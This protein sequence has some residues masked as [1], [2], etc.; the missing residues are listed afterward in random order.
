MIAV[1]T[2]FQNAA[3]SDVNAVAYKVLMYLGNYA[4]EEGAGASA[5]SSGAAA[6]Y[7]AS[8][9]IDGDRTEL[10]VGAASAADNDI[11]QSSW[12]STGVPD[13]S[14]VVTLDITFAQERKINRVKLYQLAGHGL[15]SY[16]LSYWDGAAWVV[17]AATADVVAGDQT[18]ITPTNELDVVDF[19]E[20]S[21]TKVRLQ[22]LGTEVPDDFANVVELEVYRAIDISS[23]IR[24]VSVS[25]GRDYKLQDP[26]AAQLSIAGINTDK[27]FS[28][29]YSPTAAEIEEGFVNDELRPGLGIIVKAGFDIFVGDEPE[30]VTI[31]TGSVDSIKPAAGSRRA[32]IACTDATKT[33]LR[34]KDSCKL[35]TSIDVGD[36]IRYVLNRANISDYEMEIDS[37]SIELDYF[38]T[39][40]ED[41]LSTIRDLVQSAADALFHFNT[42]GLAIFSLFSNVVGHDEVFTSQVDWETGTLSG[43]DTT[44]TPGKI[45]IDLN[46]DND[47][48]TSTAGWSNH[49]DPKGSMTMATGDG[50]LVFTADPGSADIKDGFYRLSPE[51]VGEWSF[52]FKYRKVSTTAAGGTGLA[53]AFHVVLFA[54]TVQTDPSFGK[55]T[56]NPFSNGYELWFN[57]NSSAGGGSSTFFLG[58]MDPPFGYVGPIISGGSQNFMS[59]FR[60]IKVRRT[61]TGLWSLFL[62]GVLLGTATDT[63]HSLIPGTSFTGQ[64][65]WT[66]DTTASNT[67]WEYKIR[68]FETPSSNAGVGIWTSPTIDMT[69]DL[70]A[71]GTL[72]FTHV[73]NSGTVTYETRSSPDGSAWDAWVAIDGGTG[74]ILSAL[75]RY[76]QVRIT[77]SFL[78]SLSP[79]VS[80]ITVNWTQ[81]AGT[82]KFPPAPASHTFRFDGIVRDIEMQLTDKMAGITAI[83]NDVSVQAQPIV[84]E[85]DN[86]DVKWQALNGTP[87]APVEVSNALNVTNGEVLEF[88]LQISGGMDISLMSGA[89]PAAAVVTFAGGATG[90]WIFSSIHPTQPVLQITITASGTITDLKVQGKSFSNATYL[91]VSRAQDAA[92]IND[93][94]RCQETI[95][96]KWIGSKNQALIIAEKLVENFKDPLS[97]IPSVKLNPLFH[98][99]E[100]DRADVIEESNLAIDAA[101]VIANLQHRIDVPE[102][103]GDASIETSGTLLRVPAGL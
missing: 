63:T 14:D 42:M 61:S 88:P 49:P 103:G 78:V 55:D 77:L 9:A 35:K 95:Q 36:A 7:P 8:G 48:D 68:N 1:S 13:D 92:S 32:D 39:E 102:G 70:A 87:Q 57:V 84:L 83:L 23:R 72:D 66:E 59:A 28:M 69:A 18:S 44:S 96:N 4:S 100:G 54:N 25:R 62:D 58:R 79:D 34:T 46:T 26:I 47:W 19:T 71:Y 17:F 41:A 94:G 93:N 89:N 76:L 12:R 86:A 20:V 101:F 15:S 40:N 90:S 33:L 60:N 6:N 81:N 74:Q 73:L 11:G 91:Q 31:F 85:G 5:A 98:A 80:D 27:F 50:G 22:V 24:S 21:T 99:E 29:D 10:N 75:Q 97:Y 82:A 30:M 43:I 67:V 51:G 64:Y 3:Y 38:F 56:Y 45:L 65:V 2:K 52:D 37:T 16:Q 53:I